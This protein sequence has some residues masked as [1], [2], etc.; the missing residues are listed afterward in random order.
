MQSYRKGVF[1][2]YALAIII[3]VLAI[4]L[5]VWLGAGFLQGMVGIKN[6]VT[7]TV[8]ADDK[9]SKMNSF[10]ESGELGEERIEILGNFRAKGFEGNGEIEETLGKL[11]W[12]LVVEDEKGKKAKEFGSVRENLGL[13]V[14]IPLPGKKIGR[15]GVDSK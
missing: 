9:G 5:L 10:L 6:T 14:D 13:F 15:I 12:S 2:L 7:L 11:G 3:A 1:D 8:S 4:V